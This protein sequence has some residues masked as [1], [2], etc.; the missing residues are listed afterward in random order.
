MIIG[1]AIRNRKTGTV[2]TL[3]K[4]N[5]HHHL[6][7]YLIEMLGYNESKETRLSG[8]QGFVDNKGNFLDRVE[9]LEHVKKCNQPFVKNGSPHELYSEDVW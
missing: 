1:V 2:Y 9:A 8:E 7:P 3:N 4:P 5:R 6:F